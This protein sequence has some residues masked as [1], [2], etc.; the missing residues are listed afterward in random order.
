VSALNSSDWKTR[1]YGS[2][3][4]KKT[5]SIMKNLLEIKFLIL[6][7]FQ[8][9]DCNETWGIHVWNC[10]QHLGS[11][12]NKLLFVNM[13]F[14]GFQI[15]DIV[16]RTTACKGRIALKHC[17]HNEWTNRGKWKKSLSEL[18]GEGQI[19]T[20]YSELTASLYIRA[21]KFIKVRLSVYYK[22]SVNYLSVI[23]LQ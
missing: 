7:C 21:V 23:S 10:T 15:S 18:P 9:C 22:T 20:R 1:I 12:C 6:S 14:V 3:R 11:N 13:T 4:E 16:D 17:P 8:S 2:A 19:G 5:V